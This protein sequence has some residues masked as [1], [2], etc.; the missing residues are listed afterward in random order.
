MVS[1]LFEMRL[2]YGVRNTG[3]CLIKSLALKGG[4]VY[5]NFAVK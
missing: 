3:A 2:A 4:R 5:P 1:S